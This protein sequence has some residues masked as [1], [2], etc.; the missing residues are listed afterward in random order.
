[1]ATWTVESKPTPNGDR[2]RYRCSCGHAGRW[3]A[4]PNDADGDDHLYARH[5][6]GE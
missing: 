6:L 5:G 4:N 2:Y 3:C 1:M